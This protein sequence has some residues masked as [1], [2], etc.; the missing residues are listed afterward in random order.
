[1][2]VAIELHDNKADVLVVGKC[3]KRDA[4]TILATGGINAALGNLDKKD[5]WQVHAADTIREGGYINDAKA[6]KVL[7]KNATDAVKELAKWKVKFHKETNGKITQRFFGA[8]TYRRACFVGDYTGK[9][10]LDSLVDQTLKREVRFKNEIYIVSLL[11]AKGRVNGAIGL[12]IRNGE[13][14][15]FHSKIVVLCTGGHSRMYKRSSSRFWENNGDGIFLGYELGAKFMDMEMF[16]FHPTGMVYPQEAEGLLVTEAVRGEGG[17]LTNKRGQRFMEKYA[18]EKMELSARDVVARA[19]YN[20]IKE[21]RGT[22]K[23]GVYLDISYKPK[24][25]ILSRIPRMYK[26]FKDYVN[27][28]I[29]KDKM[30]VAPTAHYSMGGIY[31]DHETGKTSIKNLFAIGEVTAGVH[32][33]N[34]LGGNSLAEI[35]IFG[36]LTGKNILKELKSIRFTKIDESLVNDKVLEIMHKLGNERGKDPIKIKK[37]IQ[38]LMWRNVGVVRKARDMKKAL[39]KLHKYKKLKFKVDNSLIMNEN[40]IAALDIRNMLPT[41]EMIIRSALFREES[42]GAHYRVDFPETLDKWKMNIICNVEEDGIR[43][44][45][46]PLKK[47][48]YDVNKFLKKKSDVSNL[49]L[50]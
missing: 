36:K 26:Q 41:C 7:C 23:K 39:K 29:S 40:L 43:I 3:E 8:A 38:N 17:I 31:V 12:D 25:Y 24:K 9:A 14:I 10:I 49:L 18:P 34:R 32:G 21:G 15:I 27:V 16:Q 37:D 47:I 45:T 11:Y 5:S 30:E 50:E 33:A 4:H 6:V 19:V 46:K 20:E 42:R 2:R 28:D 35:I 1:M 44:S 48:P 22:K 13:F